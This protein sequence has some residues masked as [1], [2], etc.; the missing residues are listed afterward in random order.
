MRFLVFFITSFGADA[1]RWVSSLKSSL[2]V[3]NVLEGGK[4]GKIEGCKCELARGS[5]KG[6]SVFRGQRRVELESARDESGEN[7]DTG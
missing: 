5:D 1:S 7:P 3:G 2:G 4:S 6:E